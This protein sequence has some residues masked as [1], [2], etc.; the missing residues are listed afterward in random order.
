[1]KSG[2]LDRRA[3]IKNVAT[4]EAV[5]SIHRQFLNAREIVDKQTYKVE[6]Q[7][8]VDIAIIAAMCICLDEMMNERNKYVRNCC[9]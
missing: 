8:G 4:G 9:L 5:A 3:E 6:I 7:Q 2:I 1:M